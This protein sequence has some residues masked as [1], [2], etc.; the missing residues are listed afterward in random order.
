MRKLIGT[1]A[2]MGLLVSFAGAEIV[3]AAI[4]AGQE[5]QQVYYT[6]DGD[7]NLVQSDGSRGCVPVYADLATCGFFF[8]NHGGVELGDDQ[9]TVAPGPFSVTC[10]SFA[11]F[12]PGTAA[13]TATVQYYD[14]DP[15]DTIHGPSL[16]ASVIPG[17][18]SGL[19][20]VSITGVTGVY[21]PTAGPDVW[22]G[23]TMP[24]LGSGITPGLLITGN[25]GGT[26]GYSHNVFEMGGSLFWFGGS[27]WA[28]F[29]EM[30]G[31][32]EPTTIGL[33]AL[34]GL[35]VLIRRR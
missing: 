1:I 6:T 2:A 35:A 34:A 33:L 18:P 24:N 26:V 14:N 8:P 9:H 4:P 20:M 10:F 31:V 15:N 23:V 29:T 17:L 13:F 12:Q 3:P 28:D 27:P 5:L 25:P 11:Y 16:G 21:A 22:M 19:V 30:T 32:P 7:G